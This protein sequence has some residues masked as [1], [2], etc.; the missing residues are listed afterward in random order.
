MS[1]FKEGKKSVRPADVSTILDCIDSCL[2]YVGKQV[3]FAFYLDWCGRREMKREEILT[4]PTSFRNCLYS[5]FG[6]KGGLAIERLISSR[7]DEVLGI[8]VAPK[9]AYGLEEKDLALRLLALR[10]KL[11][12]QYRGESDNIP[13]FRTISP[14]ANSV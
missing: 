11:G 8:A 14:I 10:R 7:L 6:N 1:E 4:D 12:L 5:L 2:N 13:I 3:I 9:R